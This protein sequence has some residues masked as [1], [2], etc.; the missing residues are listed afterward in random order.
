MHDLGEVPGRRLHKPESFTGRGVRFTGCFRSRLAA[1][2]LFVFLPAT[3]RTRL[4]SSDLDF[5][6]G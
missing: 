2:A 1:T 6:A 3:A 4:I 5:P